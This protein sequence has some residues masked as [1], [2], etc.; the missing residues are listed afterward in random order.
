MNKAKDIYEW[1][2]L[3]LLGQLE[4]CELIDFETKIKANKDFAEDVDII[5]LEMYEQNLLPSDR[6][7]LF[8]KRLQADPKL[9]LKLDVHTAT[10]EAIDYFDDFGCCKDRSMMYL[11]E[12]SSEITLLIFKNKILGYIIAKWIEWTC[13]LKRIIYKRRK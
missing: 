2:E 7:A 12:P 9:I 13:I 8:E 4:G 10:F 11:S 3:Y 5:E 6:K 1:I